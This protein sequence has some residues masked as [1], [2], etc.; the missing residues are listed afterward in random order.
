LLINLLQINLLRSYVV[1]TYFPWLS[2]FC[3]SENQRPN[4]TIL[5]SKLKEKTLPP[6][7]ALLYSAAN[8]ERQKLLGRSRSILT[9][10]KPA[11]TPAGTKYICDLCSYDRLFC[12]LL[13][14]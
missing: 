3:S 13:E 5:L 2:P 11:E 1:V 12:V 8:N 10:V 9:N 6:S 7:F 4:V 14:P